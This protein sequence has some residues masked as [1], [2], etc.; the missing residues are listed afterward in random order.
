LSKD[1][2]MVFPFS[3]EG[4]IEGEV[5][6]AGY[7]I[8]A[9][10]YKWDDYKDIDVTGKI[11]LV[12]RREPGADDPNSAFDGTETTKYSYFQSKAMNAVQ[13]GAKGMILVTDPSHPTANDNF[14]GRPMLS[15]DKEI[16][17]GQS[18]G[19]TFLAAHVS[20]KAAKA[21]LGEGVMKNWQE[22][23]DAGIQVSQFGASDRSVT[24]TVERR[25][26]GKPVTLYNVAG[27]LPAT[28]ENATETV[29][30]GA[31]YDHLGG[32]EGIEDQIYN[33][34]DDNASGTSAMIEMAEAFAGVSE[35]K[36]DMIFI[37]FSAEELGLLG[38]KAFV[39]QIDT[40]KVA[41]ML[42]FDMIGRNSDKAMSIIGDGYATE[43]SDLITESNQ[44]VGLNTKLAGD[45]YFGASD[46][47]SFFRKNRPF[48]FFFT[49][50]HDDY[51][52][53]TDHADKLD[54]EQ[55]EKV[56]QLGFSML[57]PIVKGEI[58]PVFIH[59]ISW[60]GIKLLPGERNVISAVE[61]KSRGEKA[62]LRAG[63]E[64]LLVGETSDSKGIPLRLQ[65]Q[66][67]GKEV[68]LQV[69]GAG[70]VRTVSVTRAKTGFVGIYPG[71][72][73]DEERKKLPIIESEGVLI[74]E[75]AEKGPAEKAGLKPGDIILQIN[76]NSV[77]PR[78]LGSILRRIG[79]GETVTCLVL[80]DGERQSIDMVLGE[81]P[82]R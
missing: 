9:P 72:V 65:Q 45:D 81:R 25:K 49:G 21:W 73:S 34:A 39:E 14:K 30:V 43:L 74:R 26:E 57:E 37:G 56:S 47:D 59:H 66:E 22:K 28:T 61:P 2:W 64:L 3:D 20:R 48:L 55:M 36:R 46:H 7:G 42:N 33:G 23:L 69:Q 79:A 27:R 71:T 10:E 77:L 19:P 80:R 52:Q 67:T 17:M 50:T 58:S 12:L 8:T 51:H 68:T 76:G 1:D 78:S 63:D 31:H 5:V 54:Y 4:S 40:E 13:H 82:Q 24:L 15:F 6:F 16:K 11:V 75:L 41:L 38:S 44:R 53:V 35:R 62:G 60:L 32:T 18:S 29:V 70:E